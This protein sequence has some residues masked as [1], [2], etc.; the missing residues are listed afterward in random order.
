LISFIRGLLFHLGYAVSI[1]LYS[2][3]VTPIAFLFPFKVRHPWIFVW[4]GF[5][6]WW[7]KVTCN[8]RFEMENPEDIPEE[9]CVVVSNHESSW[10]TF[11]LQSYFAPQCV[12]AKKEL[13]YIPFVGFTLRSLNPIIID[14][15]K[16]QNALKQ[17]VSQGKDRLNDGVSVLIFPEGTR[18][19]RGETKAHFAGGSMLAIQ[20]KCPILPIVHNSGKFWPP[21]KI[22]KNPGV[23]KIRVGKKIDTAGRKP[24]ELTQEIEDWMRKTSKELA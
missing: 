22:K 17:L 5:L 21:N 11:F 20:A 7:L 18:V 8:I 13:F 4:T 23:I 15:T 3:F 10:E 9:V 24:K 6:G 2:I 14:R 19:D 12:A 1:I 16:K